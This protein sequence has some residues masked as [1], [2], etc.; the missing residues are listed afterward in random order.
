VAR[1]L[2]LAA[3]ARRAAPLLPA[4]P[5]RLH[6]HFANDA[7]ALARY[8]AALTGVAYRVTAHAYDIYQDP[9]LLAPNL[10]AAEATYTVSAANLEHLRQQAAATGG[11]SGRLHLLRCGLDLAAFPFREPPPPA[12]PTRLLCIARLIPKKGHALLLRAMATLVRRSWQ[13]ELGLVGDGPLAAELRAQVRA[14]GLDGRVQF[15]GPQPAAA[16]QELL[17][18]ADVL[19]LASR[20]AADGDRDGL[21]VA[22]V[23][24]MAAGVP[25]VATRVAGIPE[26]VD[27]ATGWLAAPD[28]A[29]ALAAAIADALE[30]PLADRRARARRARARVEAGFDLARQVAALSGP[31]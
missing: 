30:E 2:R 11:E 7:A 27:E 19:V 18:A 23:E 26:L 5:V 10:A 9:F 4:D 12:E 6:A 31:A 22:L 13:L 21:P 25:V 3:C 15:H 8:I 28:D 24:A 29:D 1:A 14:L 16:T 17:R 20:V